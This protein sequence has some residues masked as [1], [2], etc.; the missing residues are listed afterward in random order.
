MNKQLKTYMITGILFV[1]I[2][3]ALSHFF[4]VWSGKNPVIALFSPVNES[5]WEHM[6]LLFFPSL[7]YT[8]FLNYKYPENNVLVPS[9]LIGIITGT[10]LIPILFYTYSGVLGFHL[11]AIDISIFFI[12]VI[13]TFVLAYRFTKNA[14]LYQ[15]TKKLLVLIAI[16]SILFFIFT[17]Y[18][19]DLGIFISPV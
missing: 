18:P 19:P 13:F 10:L 2:L 8:V 4:Y 14:S 11:T 7:L 12:C 15:Y 5:T 16:I 1:S 6:K 9:M 17:F 3:G